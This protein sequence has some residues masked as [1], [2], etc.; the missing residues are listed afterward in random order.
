MAQTQR[1]TSS[2]ARARVPLANAQPLTTE[3]LDRIVLQA[4]TTQRSY[5]PANGCE[6][7][8]R[9]T[10]PYC[11]SCKGR[12]VQPW[13]CPVC[14]TGHHFPTSARQR[15]CYRCSTTFSRGS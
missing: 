15:F 11:A 8:R 12:G 9:P 14:G 10:D 5:C 1:T 4:T 6:N 13:T 2:E 7:T 3:D